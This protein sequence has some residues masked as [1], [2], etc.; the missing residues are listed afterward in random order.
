MKTTPLQRLA[1]ALFF[2]AVFGMLSPPA[3]AKP[4][5]KWRIEVSEGAK[6]TGEI[7]FRIEPIGGQA[8]EVR[9]PVADGTRENNV[10]KA[11]RDAMKAELPADGYHVEVDDGE[12]VLVKKKGGAADFDLV[13]V[14][15][16]VKSVRI[17]LDR[18]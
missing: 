5:N 16:S 8:I 7:V 17:N 1:G 18:E 10:A 3:D 14:G 15:N 2:L 13:L 6:S 9:V 11:I 12:D 4:S